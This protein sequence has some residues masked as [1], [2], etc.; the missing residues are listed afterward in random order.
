MWRQ[1]RMIHAFPGSRR[2]TTNRVLDYRHNYSMA[3]KKQTKKQI[4]R[5]SQL[6]KFTLCI[7]LC[8]CFNHKSPQAETD[9]R[10]FFSWTFQGWRQN[11]TG[12]WL[13]WGLVEGGYKPNH[14]VPAL[15]FHTLHKYHKTSPWTVHSLG[16]K[17][18]C[19]LLSCVVF[20][21]V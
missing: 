8:N 12:W 19:E 5:F 9:E 13:Q 17:S 4:L 16:R 2:I 1:G 15:R 20:S 11:F 7:F 3:L 18:T 14:G 10:V 21:R 6:V